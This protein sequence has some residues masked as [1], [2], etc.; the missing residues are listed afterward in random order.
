MSRVAAILA[1]I[2]WAVMFSWPARAAILWSDP[3]SRVI[4]VSPMEILSDKIK[5]DDKA[6]DALYFKF[7]VDPLSD[8]ADEPYYALFQLVESNQMRLGVG[9]ALEAWG[10][11]AAYTSETGPSNK[12]NISDSGEY[13]L[14]SSHP[15]AWTNGQTRPYELPSH[16]HPRVIVF[17]VQYIPGADDLVT[18]WLDPNLSRGWSENNQ[19][20][21]LT[22]KF[23]ANALFDQI[24]LTQGG[25]GGPAHDGGN[26]WIFSDM[27]IATSFDDFVVER[28]WQT[29]WFTGLVAAVLLTSVGATVRVVEKRKYQMQLQRAEQERTLERERARIA[30]DLHD[31]LGSSL[32]RLSL[33]SGLVKADK[34]NPEQVETHANKLSQAADQTVRALEEIVWAVRP[35]SDTLQ[36]LMDYIAHF[37]NE[38]FDGNT[39][40][41]RLDLPGDLPAFPLPPDMRH[42]IFLIV[43]EAL[44]NALK[45]ARAG[46]VH[47]QAKVT[48]RTLEILVADDGKGFDP[49]SLAEGWRNGMGNL[50]RRTAAM[51]A[52]L[53]LQSAPGKGT[54]VTLKVD[55]SNRSPPLKAK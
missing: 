48:G 29:W 51:N 22:T 41:C 52:T 13:N 47:L 53:D 31:D 18:V 35:G 38:L 14:N 12:V 39:T 9:N 2:F 30:Q 17:K 26:G 54:T 37:A 15:E 28:F 6:N 1:L 5:R 50:R 55:L 19:P 24:R 7:R 23:K 33:L 10:Y 8:P 27:A 36:S 46:E 49:K 21:N 44:T 20:K 43:K 16:D 3:G 45:H 42:N 25:T 34:D 40:R 11:S 32:T 4:H